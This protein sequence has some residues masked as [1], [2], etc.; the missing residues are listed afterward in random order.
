MAFKRMDGFM[1]SVPQRFIDNNMRICPMCGTSDPHWLIDQKLQ[2]KLE[3]NLYLFQCEKCR[4]ILTS[5]VPDVT[6]FNNTAITTTG[7][8]KRLSGKKNGV[9]YIKVQDSGSAQNA[10]QHEGREFTLEELNAIAAT[11]H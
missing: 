7:L 6:G 5:P 4:C 10:K 9:I 8:L 1:G 3:G 11:L 2:L